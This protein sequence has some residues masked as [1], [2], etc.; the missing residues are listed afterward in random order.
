MVI[1]SAI[2]PL[3]DMWSYAGDTF[4]VE[5]GNGEV[6]TV[7]DALADAL[8]RPGRA[9]VRL[10]FS[11]H[12]VQMTLP[13]DQHAVQELPAQGA[14]QALADCFIS[15]VCKDAKIGEHWTPRELRHSFVPLM[16]S[17]GAPVEEIARI[18]G[19][20]EHEDHRSGLQARTAADPDDRRRSR[21]QAFQPRAS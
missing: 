14:D 19:A 3:Q 18:A 9:V 7:G 13:E 10:V 6:A 8:V 17:S 5:V 15:A 12:S 2:P 20:L 4:T 21:G 1:V 16:S 11:Q